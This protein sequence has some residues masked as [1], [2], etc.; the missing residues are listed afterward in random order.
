[1]HGRNHRYNRQVADAQIINPS[2]YP[3]ETPDQHRTMVNDPRTRKVEIS[4]RR[5]SRRAGIA[6]ARRADQARRSDGDARR[7]FRERASRN[8]FFGSR[9]TLNG[10][11]QAI[12]GLCWPG[13]LQTAKRRDRTF[14]YCDRARIRTHSQVPRPW[15]WQGRCATVVPNAPPACAPSR[16]FAVRAISSPRRRRSEPPQARKADP[17]IRTNLGHVNRE[18]LVG[19]SIRATTSR[20]P[21]KNGLLRQ[22]PPVANFEFGCGRR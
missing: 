1:M 3:S 20:Q 4:R 17:A 22:N 13:Q 15:R 6:E 21:G 12:T 2:E 10:G 14:A 18:T 11:L 5:I 16:P 19:L 7:R 8:S 9:A